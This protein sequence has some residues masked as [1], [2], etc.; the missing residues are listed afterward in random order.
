MYLQNIADTLFKAVASTGARLFL[1]KEYHHDKKLEIARKQ[2]CRGT[3][4]TDPCQFYN[5]DRDQCTVCHCIIAEKSKSYENHNPFKGGRVE[6][7]HCPKGYWFDKALAD[8]YEN[9]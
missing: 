6:I 9:N 2:K 5:K 7:T 3:S 8:F 1:V 4:T